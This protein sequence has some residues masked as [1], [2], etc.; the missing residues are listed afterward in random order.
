M[1]LVGFQMSYQDLRGHR[2]RILAVVV[3]FSRIL[4]V[5]AGLGVILQDFSRIQ[6]DHS[7][8]CMDISDILTGFQRSQQDLDV[9]VRCYWSQQDFRIFRDLGGLSRSLEV[10]AGFSRSSGDLTGSLSSWQDLVGFYTF[11]QVL[12]GCCRSYLDV[13]GVSRIQAL[14]IL[15]VFAGFRLQY[16]FRSLSRI[17]GFQCLIRI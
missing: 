1:F 5:L 9:L 4:E 10:L 2:R 3:G 13:R 6:Q 12:A 17:I 11:Q 15:V 7:G 16:D 14:D 8:L